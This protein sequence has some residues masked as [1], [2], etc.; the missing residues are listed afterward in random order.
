MVRLS[1][2]NASIA[3][4]QMKTEIANELD[5]QLIRAEKSDGIMTRDLVTRAEE[6]LE[7]KNI[8]NPS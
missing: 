4:D 7:N 2:R 3:L 6:Q 1:D 8:S 5:A